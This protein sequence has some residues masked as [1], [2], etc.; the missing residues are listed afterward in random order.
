MSTLAI[1]MPKPAGGRP[2]FGGPPTRTSFDPRPDEGGEPVHR[3]IIESVRQ[4]LVAC[5]TATTDNVPVLLRMIAQRKQMVERELAMLRMFDEEVLPPTISNFYSLDFLSDEDEVER[6]YV[7]LLSE[8]DTASNRI[9]QI[10]DVQ[11]G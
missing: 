2:P 11:M 3:R 1:P 7:R 4:V 5:T 10:E 6:V 9:K 8:L